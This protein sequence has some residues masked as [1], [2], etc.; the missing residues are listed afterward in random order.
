MVVERRM[1]TFSEKVADVAEHDEDEV[2]DVGGEEDVVWWVGIDVAMDRVAWS[3]LRDHAIFFVGAVT[4]LRVDSAEDL[5]GGRG[6]RW[7]GETVGIVIL[8]LVENRVL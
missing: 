5:L 2:A 8:F 7:K 1:E 6:P 3:V 4:E